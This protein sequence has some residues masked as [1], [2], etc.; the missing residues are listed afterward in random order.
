[1]RAASQAAPKP[2]TS[3]ARRCMDAGRGGETDG[4]GQQRKSSARVEAMVLAAGGQGAALGFEKVSDASNVRDWLH[5]SQT[6]EV[7]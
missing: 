7:G 6:V 1:M 2:V 3:S 4:D 5:E